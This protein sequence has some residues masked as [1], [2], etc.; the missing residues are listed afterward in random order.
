M[1]DD[2]D[3]TSIADPRTHELVMQLLNIIETLT[4]DLRAA[5]VEIQQLRDE[6]NRLKGEQGQPP[7]NPSP[8]P[9]D[10]SSERERRRPLERV[11]RGKRD[12]IAIDRTHDLPLD[13]A[14]LPPDAQFKGYEEV[15]VQDVIIGT[16]NVL[17]RKEKWYA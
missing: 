6:I 12:R 15:V 2:L 17:F 11:K 10:H 3:L 5:Q 9:R 1:L 4:A 14:I 13:P 8:P 7:I 16:D